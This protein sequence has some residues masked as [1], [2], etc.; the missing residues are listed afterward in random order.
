MRTFENSITV[1]TT[2]S[3]VTFVTI[4]L[5]GVAGALTANKITRLT[6]SLKNGR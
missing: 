6:F 2:V 1:Q 5:L 3:F 4:Y